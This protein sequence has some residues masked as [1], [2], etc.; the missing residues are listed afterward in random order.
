MEGGVTAALALVRWLS[1]DSLYTPGHPL[2]IPP[3]M[4]PAFTSDTDA[5]TKAR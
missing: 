5:N 4:S 3:N 1:P 2:Y